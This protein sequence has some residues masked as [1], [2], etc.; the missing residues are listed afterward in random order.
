LIDKPRSLGASSTWH[1]D[2]RTVYYGTAARNPNGANSTAQ[3]WPWPNRPIPVAGGSRGH[4]GPDLGQAWLRVTRCN[5]WRVDCTRGYTLRL[6]PKPGRSDYESGPACRRGGV[7][8]QWGDGR[9]VLW[10][11]T[12]PLRFGSGQTQPPPVLTLAAVR[13]A[14]KA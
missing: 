10:G 1:I 4:R 6:P 8:H 11:Y 13:G 5:P 14:P 9:T 3:G 7:A 2:A 12:L